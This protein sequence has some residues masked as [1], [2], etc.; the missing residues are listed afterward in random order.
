MNSLRFRT[1]QAAN[2]LIKS[3]P[4]QAFAAGVALTLTAGLAIL[5]SESP[6]A[7]RRPVVQ[8]KLPEPKSAPNS[9]PIH[10]VRFGIAMV[11]EGELAHSIKFSEDRNKRD[12]GIVTLKLNKVDE[13]GAEFTVDLQYNGGTDA[14]NF[15]L[16]FD[17]KSSGDVRGMAFFGGHFLTVEKSSDGVKVIY[18]ETVADGL[19]SFRWNEKGG[20]CPAGLPPGMYCT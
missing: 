4:L 16:E 1:R 12:S 3:R 18:A 2:T 11:K 15:R 17:G 9:V 7:A 10:K 14:M 19:N 5:P 13:K 6:K 8:E 20:G